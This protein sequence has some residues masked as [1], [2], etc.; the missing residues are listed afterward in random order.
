LFFSCDPRG[1]GDPPT[2]A[3]C[4]LDSG[5]HSFICPSYALI[6][7]HMAHTC[8]Y[9]HIHMPLIWPICLTYAHIHIHMLKHIHIL[10]HIYIYIYIY[11]YIFTYT[12]HI[13]I[14]R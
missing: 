11:I 4:G 13:Y 12:L 8:S 6:Q 1:S 14:E 3:R 5:A 7:L 10:I 9:S 2:P